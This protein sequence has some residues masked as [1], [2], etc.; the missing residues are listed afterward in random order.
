MRTTTIS[1]VAACA[2]LL[3]SAPLVAGQVTDTAL[4]LEFHETFAFSG[5]HAATIA[6]G[7]ASTV[8]WDEATWDVRG[9]SNFISVTPQGAGITNRF[10]VDIHRSP[11]ADPRDGRL[12]NSVLALGGDGGPGVGVMH[13][14][15]QD[16]LDARLRNPLLITPTQPARVSFY[17]SSFNTSGHWWEVAITP[18]DRIIG[19]E[20]SGVPGQGDAGLIEPFGNGNRQPG[21]GHDPA[22]DSINLVMFGASDVPCNAGWFVRAAVTRSVGGATTQHV[23]PVAAMNELLPSDPALAETLIHWQI[24]FRHD[25]VALFSDA[26][27]DGQWTLVEQW[28]LEVPW[29]EVHLHLLGVAYQAD[30]HPQAPCFLGHMRELR[31]REVRAAPVKYAATDVF[32][33]NANLDHVPTRTGWRAYDLRDIQRFGAAVAG[34]P[35][36]NETEF[37]TD[38]R[39]RWCRDAG[40]P[41]F[42]DDQQV[43]LEVDLPARPGLAVAEARFVYDTKDPSLRQPGA[44]LHVNGV[45]VGALPSHATVPGADGQDWVRRDLDIPPALLAA[46]TDITLDLDPGMY[47][48]RMEIELAYSLATDTGAGFSDGFEGMAPIPTQAKRGSTDVWPAHRYGGLQPGHATTH[49]GQP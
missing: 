29:S 35:Q 33:R 5:N 22:E 14:D 40:Y 3:A 28:S 18:A 9:D 39:G 36:P 27:E 20:H 31:W 21:P 16:I 26:D 47:L 32:P 13:L 30:H 11:S 8:W 10:H 25:G 2:L 41:C 7:K 44:S 38:H 45:S 49:C 19:G 24:E 12:D 37:G 1:A 48:D 23:N 34:A 43:A 46:R 17:A 4:G 42:G 6:G 15:Y